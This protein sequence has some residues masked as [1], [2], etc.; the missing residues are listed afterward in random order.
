MDVLKLPDLN[1]KL[2]G[3]MVYKSS[4][5]NVNQLFTNCQVICSNH[6]DRKTPRF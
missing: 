3:L 2:N 4:V 1:S 5:W 6:M